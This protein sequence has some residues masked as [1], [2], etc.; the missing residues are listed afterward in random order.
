MKRSTETRTSRC[1]PL[2]TKMGRI[3][4]VFY[5]R[6]WFQ[7]TCSLADQ[8]SSCV[9]PVDCFKLLPIDCT[10]NKHCLNKES[11]VLWV[12]CFI[13]IWII[14]SSKDQNSQASVTWKCSI[15]SLNSLDWIGSLWT[16]K[17]V[18]TKARDDKVVG[19]RHGCGCWWESQ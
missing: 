16:P 19:S 6:K 9:L 17:S 11:A 7:S 2:I 1:E 15:K 3:R 8:S 4:A 10:K 14:I 18:S 13:Y 5:L 12:S